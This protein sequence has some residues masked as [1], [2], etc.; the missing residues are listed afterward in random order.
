[1]TDNRETIHVPAWFPVAAI[2]ALLF[3]AFGAYQYL[4][5]VMTDPNSLTIDQRDLLLAM[6]EWMTAAFGLAVWV[7]LAGALLLLV[8]RRVAAPLLLV[9]LLAAVVQF[10]ALLVVPALRNL[11]GSDDLLV[12]FVILVV[13][14]AIWHLAWQAR[15]WGWLR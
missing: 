2:A 1:M 10:G 12:P 3:E 14:Y 5:Q 4:V 9:S 15:R 13:C 8:R 11:V 6:P 7:G